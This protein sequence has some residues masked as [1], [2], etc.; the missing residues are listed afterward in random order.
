VEIDP[1]V[2]GGLVVL[3]YPRFTLIEIATD[4][5]QPMPLG[6][7]V[8]VG[9]STERVRVNGVEGIWIGG[10]HQIGYIDRSGRYET[11]TVR[12]SGPVLLWARRGVTYR[13]EGLRTRAEALAV[14]TS[15]R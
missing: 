6:K 15:I 7:Q 1:R 9:T 10:I 4:P 11:D 8:G 12:R 5:T 13:I 2:P 14:A 3:A